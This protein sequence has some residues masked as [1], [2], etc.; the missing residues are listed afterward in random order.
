MSIH[1]P[2]GSGGAIH[3]LLKGGKV[4]LEGEVGSNVDSARALSL[5]RVPGVVAVT[6]HLTVGH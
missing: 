2:V 4:W 6:N 1:S 3:I 5:A